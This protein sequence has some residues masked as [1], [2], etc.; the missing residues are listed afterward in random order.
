LDKHVPEPYPGIVIVGPTASGKSRLG[1]R[2]ARRY[3]GEILSCDALQLYRHMD[4]GTAKVPASE[5]KEVPHHMLD[6]FDPTEEC[7]AG[8]YQNLAR[9]ALEAVRSRKRIP[10]IVGGTGFYLRALIEG[11]FEGPSRD[12]SLRARM[13]K[14]IE[15]KGAETLHRALRR[16]DPD[17]AERIAAADG[18]RIIRAFEMYL[19]SGKPMSWWQDKPRVALEGYRWLKIGILTTRERLR[20][21]IDRRVE[22]M[23]RNGF[24]EEVR[25]LIQVFPAGAPAFKA[26]GYRQMIDHIQGGIPLEEAIENTRKE[27]RRYAKR[28]MTW[29]RRDPEI[30]WIGDEEGFDSVAERAE[31]LVER[32]LHRSG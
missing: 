28:Q 18:E 4:I 32:F 27:S 6:I 9:E 1:I 12:E 3:G 26:I 14:I 23:I 25:R 10:F 19:V 7:S 8:T 30:E 16:V 5:R 21:R 17:S 22:D 13:R 24:V 2:L 11:L 15:R 29:F 31:A 20:E